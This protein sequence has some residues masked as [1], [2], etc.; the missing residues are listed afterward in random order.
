MRLLSHNNTGLFSLTDYPPG[1]TNIPPYAILSHTWGS[2]EVTYKD[3]E[4]EI[5]QH[6]IG[7]ENIR[8]CGQQARRDGLRYF[9]VDTCCIDKSSSAELA[10]LPMRSPSALP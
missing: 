7:Y 2:E 1:T 6:K 9:W 8:F 3:L 4:Q 10:D 5:G